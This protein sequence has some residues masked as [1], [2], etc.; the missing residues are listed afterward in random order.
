MK[1]ENQ[2]LENSILDIEW[3]VDRLPL[4]AYGLKLSLE[5]WILKSKNSNLSFKEIQK[6][7]N[8]CTKRGLYSN[9]RS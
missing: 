6:L 2:R 5:A 9:L 4:M 1:K 8:R 7:N 3:F